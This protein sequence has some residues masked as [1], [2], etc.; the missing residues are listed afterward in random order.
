MPKISNHRIVPFSAD[1]IYQTVMNIESYPQM[2]SFV[3]NIGILEKG[4]DYIIA[5]VDIGLPVLK[6]SYTCRIEFIKNKS[7]QVQLISG[8]F[9]RMNADWSFE[10]LGPEQTKVSYAL[11][12]QFNNLLMEKTAGVLFASQIHYSIRAF[13]ECL[14]RS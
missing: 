1:R 9:Q 3:R 2:L 8:P 13:E 4:I 14:S 12:A 11:D 6:F 7:I 5:R 10:A